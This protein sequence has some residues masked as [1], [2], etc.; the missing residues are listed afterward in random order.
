MIQPFDM[1]PMTDGQ[2]EY[3]E[4]FLCSPEWANARE[5]AIARDG[6][7]CRICGRL[8]PLNVHHFNYDDL[9]DMDN[10]VTVCRYCHEV[11]TA[12]VKEARGIHYKLDMT[13]KRTVDEAAR[14]MGYQINAQN[15]DLVARI[16][17]ELYKASIQDD[18][19]PINISNL[20][21]VKPIARIVTRTL[22]GQVSCFVSFAGCNYKMRLDDL[23]RQYRIEAYLHYAVQ[24]F[25]PMEIQRFLGLNDMQMA[26]VRRNVRAVAGGG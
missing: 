20:S 19:S 16:L 2:R 15:G 3:R 14:T 9:L 7:K 1:E 6:G 25:S 10:L 11:L 4:G 17:L 22:D 18:G 23:V 21:T 24:G 26:K 13:R 12:A 5:R 8:A